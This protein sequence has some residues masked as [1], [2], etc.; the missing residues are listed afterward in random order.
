MR[1]NYNYKQSLQQFLQHKTDK[2]V[3]PI[4]FA[5]WCVQ[6]ALASISNIL[7]DV[8]DNGGTLEYNIAK[9]CKCGG[10]LEW[11]LIDEYGNIVHTAEQFSDFLNIEITN[12]AT[13]NT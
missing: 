9:G 10:C 11:Q 5:D 13:P 3:D 4:K 12:N 7:Y 8:I 6:D 2:S 1:V